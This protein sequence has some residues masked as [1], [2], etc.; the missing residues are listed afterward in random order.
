MSRNHYIR[1]IIV[2][3][4]TR[5]PYVPQESIHGLIGIILQKTTDIMNLGWDSIILRLLHKII[6]RIIVMID[7]IIHVTIEGEPA[8][9]EYEFIPNVCVNIFRK[10]VTFVSDKKYVDWW[11]VSYSEI[12]WEI[13]IYVRCPCSMYI[14]IS[15][16]RCQED[17]DTLHHFN[18]WLK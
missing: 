6:Y 16:V 13:I 3:F 5:Q 11:F 18:H 17:V 2:R 8:R 14:D 12:C 7:A 9:N 1:V 10:C 15:P 4:A